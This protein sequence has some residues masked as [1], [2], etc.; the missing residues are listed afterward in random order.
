MN[1][2]ETLERRRSLRALE[3]VPVSDREV[4]ALAR[5]ASL[6][7]SCFNNQPWRFVFVRDRERLQQLWEGV[8]SGNDWTRRASMVVAVCA[9]RDDDCVVREREYYL[10]DSG[11]A[12]AL[13]MLKA[14]ELGLI[15][16]AIAGFRSDTVRG[17]LE[18]PDDVLLITLII[19]G[20]PA[21][22]PEDLLTAKQLQSEGER[23]PR[24]PLER[25]RMPERFREE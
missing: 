21:E 8:S 5:A 22:N 4:D 3:P 20:A 2:D 24:L 12:T 11:M 18:I 16:H 14:T 13:L 6:A 15:A 7:P 25:I 17:I 1:L 9:R 23:P 10:F 19:C